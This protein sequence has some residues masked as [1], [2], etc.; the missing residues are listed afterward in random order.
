VS[1]HQR[2]DTLNFRLS[3]TLKEAR[4]RKGLSLRQIANAAGL[5]VNDVDEIERRPAFVPLCDMAAFLCALGGAPEEVASELL[6][7]NL[8]P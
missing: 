4:I 5:Q 2:I 1:I 7:I 3:N 8:G 6:N